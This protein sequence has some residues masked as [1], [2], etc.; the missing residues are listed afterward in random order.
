MSVIQRSHIHVHICQAV[1]ANINISVI[2]GRIK[3]YN[4]KW[5]VLTRYF[6]YRGQFIECSKR[7]IN[8]FLQLFIEITVGLKIVEQ[9]GFTYLNSYFK[10]AINFNSVARF[11]ALIWWFILGVMEKIRLNGFFSKDRTGQMKPLWRKECK[12]LVESEMFSN[13]VWYCVKVAIVLCLL[14]SHF[15]H[16]SDRL[17]PISGENLLRRDKFN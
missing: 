14:V 9:N 8:T 17:I 16:F 5:Y 10:F 3:K 13:I 15:L 7:C 11:K 12:M 1:E 6:K 2:I 4:A